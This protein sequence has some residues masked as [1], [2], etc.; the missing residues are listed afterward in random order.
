MCA[1]LVGVTTAGVTVVPAAGIEPAAS[2]LG[3]RRSIRLSYVGVP[4]VAGQH[5]GSTESL[6]QTWRF[7][8]FAYR[9]GPMERK[10]D[11]SYSSKG[12]SSAISIGCTRLSLGSI[13]ERTAGPDRPASRNDGL[14]CKVRARSRGFS[15]P[16]ASTRPEHPQVQQG[17]D[18]QFPQ[19]A[20]AE[21]KAFSIST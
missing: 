6:P 9:P 7:R 14:L 8:G 21:A 1:P 15:G 12:E 18:Q 11:S 16:G 20:E 2:G 19:I 10:D 13:P 4:G 17:E 5:G 3:N